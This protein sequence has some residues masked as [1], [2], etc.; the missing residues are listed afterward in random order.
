MGR[1]VAGI[2][3]IVLPI[4]E[5]ALLIKSGQVIGF[6]ATLALLIG[7]A[8]AGMMVLSRLGLSTMRR[9]QEA[10]V[11]GE[12][13]VGPM[14]D[15]MFLFLAGMLLLVPGFIT[16]ALA[17]LLLVPPIR[18]WVARWSV[19]RMFPGAGVQGHPFAGRADARDTRRTRP[20]PGMGSGPVI[21]G[22]FER[23]GEKPADQRGQKD[24]D[25]S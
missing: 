23:L 10:L 9:S 16:D 22:E 5:M 17:L 24:R 11:R 13:P 12:P 18:S 1:W 20:P 3:F 21:E 25:P 19:R 7:A 15:S 4:A 6:W 8:F 14:L 2:L